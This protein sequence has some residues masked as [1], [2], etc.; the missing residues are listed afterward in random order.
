ML[1]KKMLIALGVAA[2][3]SVSCVSVTVWAEENAEEQTEEAEDSSNSEGEE[4][5]DLEESDNPEIEEGYTTELEGC[6]K[7]VSWCKNEDNNIYGQFYYPED[8]DETKTYPVIIMSHGIGSTSQMV[9][10]AKWPERAAQDGYVVYTFDFC[11]GSLNG[12][13]DVDFMDMTVMTEK[14][15][16]SAVM[17]F[18][19]T[20]DY[21]DQDHLFLLG[22]S[23]GG[24]VSAL[25]AADRKDD[26][27]A[28]ILI[29]PAFCIADNAREMY[30]SAYDIPEDRAEMP[31]GTV[32]SEYVKTVYDLDVYGTISAYDGD[33]MIIHG[34]NDSLVPYSYSEKAIEEARRVMQGAKFLR[35]KRRKEAFISE[36]ERNEMTRQSQFL[37][38]ELH[39]KKQAYAEQI[40]TAQTAVNDFQDQI[41]AW[42]RERKL[43]ES[44]LLVYYQ[45]QA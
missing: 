7:V 6:T 37:K 3:L 26:V 43:L 28:M 32:G 2:V 14:E 17:D 13:S 12:N 9:E 20:K 5:A 25:T 29:Y 23:Q 22:Q 35:D 27:A 11:G 19:K 36:E 24:L 33:V 45:V 15:D 40:T 4:D 38:A 31:V 34:I 21:V 44:P 18:V 8:F 42:K 39:R 10:R 41:T 30:D 16:L 1:K